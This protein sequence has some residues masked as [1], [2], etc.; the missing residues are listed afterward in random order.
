MNDIYRLAYLAGLIAADGHISGKDYTI[1]IYVGSFE[2]T[3]DI[4]RM[5]EGYTDNMVGI[6]FHNNVYEVY[7][8]DK[9]LATHFV[10]RYKIP[11]GRKYDKLELPKL[12]DVELNS[13]IAGLFD[14]DGSIYKRKH[15]AENNVIKTYYEVKLKSRSTKLLKQIIDYLEKYNICFKLKTYESMIPYIVLSRREQVMR[16]FKIIPLKYKRPRDLPPHG[17]KSYNPGRTTSGEGA[18]LE[19]AR[20]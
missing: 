11:V 8:T 16:F 18:R 2:R 5:L 7:V 19:R 13:F 15:I 1:T 20:R 14:G 3:K 10:N 17:A 12:D 4:K 6:R 9:Q